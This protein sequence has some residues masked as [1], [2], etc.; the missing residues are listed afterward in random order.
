MAARMRAIDSSAG[1]IGLACGIEILSMATLST[2]PSLIPVFQRE[3][4][5]TNSEAGIISGV[6]F[7]GLLISVAVLTSLTDRFNAKHIFVASLGL[8]FLSGLGFAF[9]ASGAWSAGFW[10]LLQGVALGGTYMPGLR[11]L[12]DLLREEDRSRGTAFYTASYYL[13]AGLSYFVTLEAE[14]LVGWS[15]TFAL[16][17]AGPLLAFLLAMAIMPPTGAPVVKPESRLLDYRPVLT[18]RQALGFSLVYA[19]HNMELMAFGSWLV[20]FL[21]FSLSLQEPGTLGAGWNLGTIA[22]LVTIVGLPSSILLNE[23]AH[24]VGR[25]RVIV[26]VM[27]S[28]GLV[29]VA[30]GSL[31]TAPY[32]LVVAAA[33]GYS[34]T[35]AGESA[36]VTGGMVRVAD[37][38]IKGATM[39]LYSIIGFAGAFLGPVIFGAVLDLAGGEADPRAWLAAF[40]AIALLLLL[41]P[42]ATVTLVGLRRPYY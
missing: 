41:G 13:A 40:G 39:S 26:G 4:G 20:P 31:A 7:G 6:F 19:V 5:I 12:T 8:A 10:R 24:R 11:I 38:R 34:A 22:A 21:V 36:T 25:Q 18:N 9:G 23:V 30:F 27:L 28:S 16:C 17:A 1:L 32:W 2:F 15:W 29:A 35:T 3:W 33:F 42:L 14:A 37:P